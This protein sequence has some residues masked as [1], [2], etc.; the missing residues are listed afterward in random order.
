MAVLTKP[1]IKSSLKGF[2]DAAHG[3]PVG[4]PD[5]EKQDKT[6]GAF[7]DWM[8]DVLKNQ[9]TIAMV[10]NGVDSNGDTLTTNEGGAL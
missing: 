7:A 10:N 9:M 5:L 4:A 2:L 1:Q 6:T 8:L 3:A